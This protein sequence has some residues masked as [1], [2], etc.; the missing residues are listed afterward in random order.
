MA[1][2]NKSTA[3]ATVENEKAIENTTVTAEAGAAVE[4]VA[5]KE[6]KAVTPATSLVKA[7]PDELI[8]A[9]VMLNGKR[10]DK[11]LFAVLRKYWYGE[12]ITTAGYAEKANP[13]QKGKAVEQV[14]LHNTENFKFSL[15]SVE[16]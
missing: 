3:P 4:Q 2:S 11:P 1:K 14:T 8:A 9:G 16:V 15:P 13:G 5:K 7:T 6:V 12:A 10:M